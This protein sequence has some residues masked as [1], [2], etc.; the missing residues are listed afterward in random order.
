MRR[1]FLSNPI[2][3]WVCSIIGL[4]FFWTGSGY[5]S[6]LYH[7]IDFADPMS[8][9][10]LTEG[11]GYVFQIVG[12]I[13]FSTIIYKKDTVISDLKLPIILFIFELLLIVLSSTVPGLALTLFFGFLMNIGIGLISGYYLTL[14]ACQVPTI[15]SGI[16]FGIGYAVGS[17][18]SW[19]LS[20][21]G[22]ENFLKTPYALIVYGAFVLVT[23]IIQQLP[24]QNSLYDSASPSNAFA[25]D[26]SNDSRKKTEG[27]SIIPLVALIGVTV[28]FLSCVKNAG[29]YFPTA[30]LSSGN[31]SLEFSRVFYAVGIIIA[32]IIN[33]RSR[34]WGAICCVM[35][36]FFPFIM[37]LLKDMQIASYILWI[38]GYFFFGFFV[39]YRV[40]VFSDIASSSKNL[41][42][43]SGFG[44]LFGRL[45]DVAGTIVGTL[46]STQKLALVII[47]T[48]LLFVAIAAFFVTYNKLYFTVPCVD[49]EPENS[50]R[51]IEDFKTNHNLSPREVEVFDLLI[52]GLSNLE[53]ATQ[54]FITE[55][56]VKFHI[57]N[58]LKK[59]ECS[60]RTELITELK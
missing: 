30:D 7:V 60:N 57:K 53:I 9:D 38:L 56:T 37:L 44:L 28:F 40:I 23:I 17:V 36:L 59:T 4:C 20:I 55:N 47:T 46:L 51:L 24:P 54:L 26:S 22:S 11:I 32:G 1:N 52:L 5:L 15:N 48:L 29:F 58:I 49:A 12:I 27:P 31:V 6:W 34:K 35:A 33:D 41:V 13:I 42:F 8:V 2:T 10:L 45:G 25:N 50:D 43:L 18:G 39:V 21:I 16:C 3:I 14:L 19:L